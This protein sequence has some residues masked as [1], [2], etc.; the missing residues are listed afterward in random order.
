MSAVPVPAPVLTSPGF[1]LNASGPSAPVTVPPHWLGW[2]MPTF[3]LINC[4]PGLLEA[5]GS[6]PLTVA[7]RSVDF[8]SRIVILASS[9]SKR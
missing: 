8:S 3:S 1:A 9:F 5:V 2:P 4:Q 7:S 6:A